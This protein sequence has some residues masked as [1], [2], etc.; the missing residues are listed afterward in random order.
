MNT[1]TSSRCPTLALGICL[2]A[3]MTLAGSSVRAADIEI[4]TVRF[5]AV[6]RIAN[7]PPIE[8]RWY[9]TE[10]AMRM[11]MPGQQAPGIV[12]TDLP[13]LAAT[14]ENMR[15]KQGVDISFIDKRVLLKQ[16]DDNHIRHRQNPVAAMRKIVRNGAELVREEE[17]AG[18]VAQVYRL[19]KFDFFFQSDPGA[20]GDSATLWVDRETRL[21]VRIELKTATLDGAASEI[22]FDEFQWNAPLD[23]KLFSLTPPPGFA[24]ERAEE[25]ASKN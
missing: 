15:L 4:K 2:L 16:L 6:G 19:K 5:R 17:I 8:Q 11:E 22:V 13:L 20:N 3:G 12:E 25:T 10:D 7:D 18:R 1:Y 24:V 21:P 14:I 23:P 9:L